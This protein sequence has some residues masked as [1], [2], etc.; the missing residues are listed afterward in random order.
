MAFLCL[1]KNTI[2]PYL[3]ISTLLV[4]PNYRGKG[5]GSQILTWAL[6]HA[7][8]WNY[9]CAIVTVSEEK[10]DSLAFFVKNGFQIINSEIG[11]YKEGI[12]EHVLQR[13]LEEMKDLRLKSRYLAMIKQGIK[14]LE[15]RANHKHVLSIRAGEKIKL[16]NRHCDDSIILRVS[17]IRR[18]TS[19]A[20]ML[21]LEDYNKLIP[22]FS[23]KEQVL[24]EYRKFYPDDKIKRVGGVTVFEFDICE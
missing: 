16:F 3:K 18:Y 5:V 17:D 11:K 21:E 2:K 1:K 19:I 10:P 24:A 9:D 15:C 14:P 22:G 7:V 4:L 20:R 13:T 23:S 8:E 6:Q 12:T